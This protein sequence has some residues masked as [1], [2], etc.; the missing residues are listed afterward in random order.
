M[1]QKIEEIQLEE[2]GLMEGEKDSENWKKIMPEDGNFA[3]DEKDNNFLAPVKKI[4]KKKKKSNRSRRSVGWTFTSYATEPPVLHKMMKCL[5]YQREVCPETKREHWQCAFRVNTR[6]GITF[7]TV[8]KEIL[9]KGEHFEFSN[10]SWKQ[11]L[12]YCSK[13]ETRK[14][15]LAEPVILGDPPK[16][17]GDNSNSSLEEIK[18]AVQQHVPLKEIADSNF[19]A[20]IRN[21]RGVDRYIDMNIQQVTKKYELKD[22]HLNPLDLSKTCVLIGPTNIGKTWFALAHFKNPLLV[23][24][25]DDLKS[26]T[27]EHDGIVFDDFLALDLS[28]QCQIH[29]SDMDLPSSIN[30]K[31]SKVTIPARLPRIFTGNDHMFIVDPAIDRRLNKYFVQEIPYCSKDCKDHKTVTLSVGGLVLPTTDVVSRHKISKKNDLKC[32]F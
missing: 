25:L 6:D 20:W 11:N 32:P 12:I 5:I 19:T 18:V 2:L 3:D 22:Y 4:E 23:R 29:I 31:H 7:D 28:R 26:L 16:I 27:H 8:K 9:N 14:D 30:V 13:V 1:E 21:Y 10:G 24:H 15:P 17:E